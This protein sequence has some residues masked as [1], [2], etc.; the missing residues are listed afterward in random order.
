M[1]ELNTLSSNKHP[2]LCNENLLHLPK[3]VVGE[4][5]VQVISRFPLLTSSI[6]SI[7]HTEIKLII[8]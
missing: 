1:L 5:P 2:A 7:Y 4:F 8:C 6:W 3:S